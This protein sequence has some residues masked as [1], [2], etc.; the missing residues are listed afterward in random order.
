MRQTSASF[1]TMALLA[2]T[3]VFAQSH[4]SSAA[5]HSTTGAAIRSTAPAATRTTSSPTAT[6]PLSS[7]P[8]VSPGNTTSMQALTPG[9]MSIT[10][11]TASPVVTTTSPSTASTPG[12]PGSPNLSSANPGAVD[13]NAA[14]DPAQIQAPVGA[15]GTP[16]STTSSTSTTTAMPT[17]GDQIL[18]ANGVV[19]PNVGAM[20]SGAVPTSPNGALQSRGEVDATSG[21]SGGLDL[22][23]TGRNMPECMAAWDTKTHITKSKWHQICA[24]T[25]TEEPH[26]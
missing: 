7:S 9:T 6:A 15:P 22:G 18:G 8:A 20:T 1:L 5:S 23:A 12:A 17:T 10:S 3:P 19:L 4:G 25:L 14:T 2:A 24:R 21:G 13:Q 11:S 26:I 16:S